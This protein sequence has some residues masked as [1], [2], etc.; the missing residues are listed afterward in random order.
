MPQAAN[1]FYLK[2]AGLCFVVCAALSCRILQRGIRLK[3]FDIDVSFLTGGRVH[4]RGYDQ[5]RL[6]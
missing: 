3:P 5:D 1:A 4:G 6:L 2:V